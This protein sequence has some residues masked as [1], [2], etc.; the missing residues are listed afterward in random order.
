M[1]ILI[2]VRTL[3]TCNIPEAK[4]KIY[5][6]HLFSQEIMELLKKSTSLII[7][8]CFLSNITSDRANIFE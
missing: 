7:D 5:S 3:E 8:N 1:Y 2:V 4:R 6:E